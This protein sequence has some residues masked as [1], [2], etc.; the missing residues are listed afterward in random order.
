MTNMKHVGAYVDEKTYE[1]MERLRKRER[2]V[3]RSAWVDRAIVRM[4][5][6]EEL[7]LKQTKAG[8]G[9]LE[10]TA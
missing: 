5:E 10:A 6:E 8:S 7:K 4:V 1:R 9:A 3:S 2:R